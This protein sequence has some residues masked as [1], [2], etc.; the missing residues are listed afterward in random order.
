MGRLPKM[1]G[2]VTMPVSIRKTFDQSLLKNTLL[3]LTEPPIWHFQSFDQRSLWMLTNFI[4]TSRTLFRKTIFP[5]LGLSTF[6][7]VTLIPDGLLMNM[8][9]SDLMIVSGSLM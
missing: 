8:V 4:W 6:P 3:R 5:Y 2:I 9:S 7:L 1:G